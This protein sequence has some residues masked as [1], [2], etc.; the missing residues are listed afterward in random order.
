MLKPKIRNQKVGFTLV[1]LLVVITIIGILI[2]LLLPAVQAARE[3]ARRMQCTNNLKQIGLALASYESSAKAFPMGVYWSSCPLGSAKGQRDGSCGGRNGWVIAILPYLELENIYNSLK[4]I[5]T[6]GWSASGGVNDAVY[7]TNIT[8]YRCPSDDPGKFPSGSFQLSR[9]NYVGCFSP[10]GTLVEKSAYPARFYYDSGPDDQSGDRSRHF[11]LEHLA[12]RLRTFPMARPT[13][14]PCRKRL[15]ARTAIFAAAG[16]RSGATRIRT[17]ERRTPRFP[18]P[19]GAPWLYRTRCCVSTPDNP[20]DGSSP[21]WSTEN[22]AARSHHP[23]GV[24]GCLLDGSVHFF[25]DQINLATWHA[26]GSIDG[27][28][29]MPKGFE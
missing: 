29:V 6:S 1:E 24:N 15:R 21:Y 26:L 12:D 14:S 19:C 4:L 10:D 18:T 2:A 16:G 5:P 23:G 28:E 9:S 22:Y 20:C 17:P 3:A 25:S 11:Q 8:A 27:H 13:R 7:T